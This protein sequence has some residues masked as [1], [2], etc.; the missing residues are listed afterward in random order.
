MEDVLGPR[1]PVG[2]IEAVEDRE[3]LIGDQ[4]GRATSGRKRI[5]T[6][7]CSSVGSRITRSSRRVSGQRRSDVGDQVAFGVEH[8]QAAACLGVLDDEVDQQRRLSRPG[9]TE[10]VGVQSGVGGV[11]GERTL[12]PGK[13][14]VSEDPTRVRHC[15]RWCERRAAGR[16]HRERAGGPDRQTGDGDQLGE[17]EAERVAP[18]LRSTC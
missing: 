16:A 9:R 6:D 4:L 11:Q 18:G 13:G 3:Q 1:S 5:E 14:R 17:V 8:Q 7:R 2:R 10:H 15:S 12:T